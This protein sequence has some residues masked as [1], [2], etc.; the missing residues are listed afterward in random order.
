MLLTQDINMYAICNM[1]VL[2]M[3]ANNTQTKRKGLFKNLEKWVN[4]KAKYK[5]N[6]LIAGDM[7]CCLRRQDRSSETHL[8]DKSRNILENVCMNINVKDAWA[9]V[10]PDL[11]YTYKNEKHEMKSRPDYIFVNRPVKLCFED[12]NSLYAHVAQSQTRMRPGLQTK[13]HD[14]QEAKKEFTCS[15]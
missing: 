3:Y 4:K 2:N 6:L 1:Y 5:E 14:A 9:S 12:V 15:T 11:G 10:T 7:N 13:H 8:T